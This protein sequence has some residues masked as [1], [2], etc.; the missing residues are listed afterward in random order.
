MV[1]LFAVTLFTSSALMFLVQPMIAKMLLPLLGGSPAVWNT[2]MVFFQ[3]ILLAGYL[4]AHLTSRYFSH[5]HQIVLHASLVVVSLLSVPILITTDVVPPSDRSPVWWLLGLLALTAGLPLFTIS[6]TSPL[7]QR[8]FAATMERNPY[9]LYAAGNVGSI[10]ALVAYPGMFEPA[11]TLR[12][13]SVIWAVGYV[14]FTVLTAA[15]AV[16]VWRAERAQPVRLQT[17]A[18]RTPRPT[19]ITQARWVLLA[20][21]PSSLMLGVTTFLTTDIAAVPLLWVL[22]L[23]VYLL[24][25]VLV[26]AHR[27]LVPHGL[28]VRLLAVFVLPVVTLTVFDSRLP[29]GGQLLLHLLTFFLAAMVCHGELARTRPDSDH[30]TIFYLC[31]AIGGV[32]GGILNAILAPMLFRSIVEYPLMIVLVCL[33]RPALRALKPSPRWLDV[34]APIALGV[35]ALGMMRLFNGADSKGLFALV[36]VFIVPAVTC[37]SFRDRPLRFAAGVAALILASTT[38]LGAHQAVLYRGRSFFSAHRIVMDE[39]H[40][41]RLFVHGGIVHGSQSVDAQQ[42]REATAYFHRTGPIGQVFDATTASPKRRVGVVGLGIGSL[43]AYGREGESWTFY[44]IDPAVA[45]LAKDVRYFTYLADSPARTEIVL[46]DARLS[47]QRAAEGEFDL[48]ILDAFSSDAVPVH[49]LTREALALYLSKLAPGGMLAFNIS[50][51]YVE[52][53]PLLGDLAGNAGLVALEQADLRVKPD[54]I[55]RGKYASRWLIMARQ[56][57]TF[58]ELNLDTRWRV[59]TSRSRPVIWTDDFSNLLSV[60]KWLG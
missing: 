16:H 33:M 40:R 46:G 13:Q 52:L 22:P 3:S 60:F 1:V 2:C 28:M 23:S 41:F 39:H 24:T 31:L 34:G 45:E 4:Y 49:L 26:F 17:A 56:A 37:F 15:C 20:F 9:P 5:K 27:T 8:W 11:L 6:S 57:S 51:R 59:V 18:D 47:L 7:F 10:L 54:Q 38:Y 36:V 19:F 42:R 25:F 58:G 55:D 30:L 14:G 21:I 32:L 44:E 53:K 35:F 12:Y 29:G 48:L 43:A 50:N